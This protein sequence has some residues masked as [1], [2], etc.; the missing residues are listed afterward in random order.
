MGFSQSL[1]RTRKEERLAWLISLAWLLVPFPAIAQ[2]VQGEVLDSV[3]GEPIQGVLVVLLDSE[4]REAAGDLTNASGRF[5]LRAP[6][7]GLFRI[8]AERLGYQV[9]NSEDLLLTAERTENVVVRMPVYPID[10]SEVEVHGE[11]RCVVR[12]EEGLALAKTWEAA[13]QV[14]AVQEW[15]AQQT[16]RQYDIALHHRQLSPSGTRVRGESQEQ[17]GVYDRMPFRALPVEELL[18]TGFIRPAPGGM[19]YEYF[20]PDAGLLL[21]DGFL[22]THCFRLAESRETPDRIGLAFEPVKTETGKA[23]IEGVLWLNRNTTQLETLEFRYTWNPFG[24]GKTRAG[25]LVNFHQLQDGRWI[26]KDWTIRM[27]TK[28]AYEEIAAEVVL[29]SAHDPSG[30]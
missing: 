2:G 17:R 3:T 27:P 28:D 26:V 23:D 30:N 8:R 9:W 4:A 22:D 21:S 14:L 12:P 7:E 16:D 6:A 10:L 5:V 13:R 29:E 18:V 25:G 1:C 11:Q 20:A 19:Q 24:R 15:T